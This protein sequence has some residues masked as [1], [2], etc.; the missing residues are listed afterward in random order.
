MANLA[1][2][3]AMSLQLSPETE[4]FL[5]KM[6]ESGCGQD[7]DVV[8]LQALRLLKATHDPFAEPRHQPPPSHRLTPNGSPHKSG[9]ME[10]TG[11]ILGDI[12]N[13]SDLWKDLIKD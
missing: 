11:E 1:E 10:G 7:A 5:Q 8:V 13:T 6:V 4:L 2:K 9:C 3:F 12:V